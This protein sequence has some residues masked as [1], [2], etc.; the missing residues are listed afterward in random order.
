M[1]LA[2]EGLQSAIVSA[3]IVYGGG[4]NL[5]HGIFKVH[6]STAAYVLHQPPSS[7]IHSSLSPQE[8]WICESAALQVP[9][10]GSKKG[11]NALPMIHVKDLAKVRASRDT[12]TK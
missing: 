11:G 10:A 8:A 2:K 5:L 7:H 4:E 3:G 1:N 9:V 6:T 12:T